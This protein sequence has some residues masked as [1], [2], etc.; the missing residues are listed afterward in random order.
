MQF[1]TG[2]PRLPIGGFAELRP[3]LT[4]VRKDVGHGAGTP[5]DHLPSCSTCQVYLK[6]PAYSCKAVLE[7]RLLQAVREGQGHFALD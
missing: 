2:S 7:R 5:D 4:V 3:R 1:L 6:L